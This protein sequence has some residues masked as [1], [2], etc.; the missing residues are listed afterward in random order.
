MKYFA[1]R[2]TIRTDILEKLTYRGI[3]VPGVKDRVTRNNF[4]EMDGAIKDMV[5]LMLRGQNSAVK[6]SKF[7]LGALTRK[8]IKIKIKY[9]NRVEDNTDISSAT[10][11]V[12][13]SPDQMVTPIYYEIDNV[14]KMQQGVS[15]EYIASPDDMIA[16]EYP[17]YDEDPKRVLEIAHHSRKNT[18][19]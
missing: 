8:D 4:S 1:F 2:I 17:F 11:V 15:L 9:E 3:E 7:Y 6:P 19:R 16:E 14:R 18:E 12:Y 5:I 10:F 13:H